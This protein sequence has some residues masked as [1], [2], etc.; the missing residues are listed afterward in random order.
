MP[1]TV[2]IRP[3]T[4]PGQGARDV[5]ADG[6]VVGEAGNLWDAGV[7]QLGHV[8]RS[9]ARRICS[10]VMPAPPEA[11]AAGLGG[12]QVLPVSSTI[13][14]RMN[15]ASA[16]K[17]CKTSR[18]PGPHARTRVTRDTVTDESL[19]IA[20]ALTVPESVVSPTPGRPATDQDHRWR[21]RLHG[22]S[23]NPI[24]SRD[25]QDPVPI[26][27]TGPGLVSVMGRLDRPDRRNWLRH[28]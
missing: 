25:A 21:Q 2:P 7:V 27:V 16:A 23:L 28:H 10:A 4:D 12:A 15:S 18:P 24:K 26:L 20:A 19:E 8:N 11:R 6:G 3:C 13:S 5:L 22:P 1:F 17:T 14:P 9:R